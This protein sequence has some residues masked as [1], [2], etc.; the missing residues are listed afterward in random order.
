MSV[1]EVAIPM[2]RGRRT[3]HV[4]KGVRWSII[5]HLMLEAVSREPSTTAA[6]AKSSGLHRRI[7]VE[8]FIRLMRVGWVE[9]LA[10]KNS[11]I[12]SATNLGHQQVKAGKLQPITTT[13]SREMSFA[14]DQATGQGFRG[15]DFSIRQRNK[16]VKADDS[17]GLVFLERDP[18]F[19]VEDIGRIYGALENENEVIVGSES[20]LHL[21]FEGYAIVRVVDGVIEELPGRTGELLRSIILKESE[22]IAPA[23]KSKNAIGDTMQL[24]DQDSIE[25]E[26]E[27]EAVF[28][29]DDLILGGD[30]HKNAFYEALKRARERV[31]IHSTFISRDFT[32][33]LPQL[34]AVAAK[35]VRIDI[36][37]GQSDDVSE[38]S[39]T[40]RAS[41]DLR[42][43]VL[44]SGRAEQI[45]IHTLSTESHSKL[46]ISDDGKGRWNAIVGSCNWLSTDFGSFE[47]SLKLRDPTLVAEIVNHLAIMSQGSRGVWH[48]LADDL[49]VLARTIAQSSRPTGKR[50]RLRVLL[51]SDHAPLVLEARDK[52]AKRMIVTSH[53]I[54]I[55]GQPMTIIPAVAAAEKNKV[56]VSLYFGRSTGPLSGTDVADLT[57]RLEQAG[58]HIRPIFQP[59]LHSKVLAWD[60]DFLAVTSQ[61]WLSAASSATQPRR[62]IGVFVKSNKVADLFV[63][64]FDHARNG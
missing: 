35:N 2:L 6:L 58:V 1:V 24:T 38:S 54:G 39:S 11:T 28:E 31:V 15:G 47:S 42:K 20:A 52:A 34:I 49:T 19:F 7:V 63:R 59:R 60:D 33:F 55:A 40:R 51:A 5:E 41:A 12:F 23:K 53:R 21:P 30:N 64:V 44:E 43:T 13:R 3:F 4:E 37:W 9:I 32:P 62:E 14:F 25:L 48:K 8:A 27:I 46:L 26:K 50:A 16:L 17:D 45:R 61:N 18:R 36:L 56:D 57:R 22:K 29:Q 10:D